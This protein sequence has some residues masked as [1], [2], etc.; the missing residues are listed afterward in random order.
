MIPP[1]ADDNEGMYGGRL[2]PPL[3]PL[4]APIAA[5]P[6]SRPGPAPSRARARPKQVITRLATDARCVGARQPA[7]KDVTVRYATRRTATTTFTLQR[8]TGPGTVRSRCPARQPASRR[9][10]PAVYVTATARRGAAPRAV[11]GSR[12]LVRTRTEAAGTH[13]F[14]ILR[15]FGVRSLKPGRYR[16]R[17][18]S[19]TSDDVRTPV[20]TVYLWVLKP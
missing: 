3:P 2:V 11:R 4:P 18:A 13:R 15:T 12:R 7:R 8:R 10:R 6:T 1:I 20:R 9:E 16:L 5:V 19:R 17:I 14:A